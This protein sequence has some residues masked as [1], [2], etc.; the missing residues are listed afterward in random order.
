[1]LQY[2]V[3]NKELFS[4]YRRLTTILK[5]SGTGTSSSLP[6]ISHSGEFRR[7][8]FGVFA[9]TEKR[10]HNRLSDSVVGSADSDPLVSLIYTACWA[11]LASFT[12]SGALSWR[13]WPASKFRKQRN[14]LVYFSSEHCLPCRATLAS[15]TSQDQARPLPIPWPAPSKNFP[16]SF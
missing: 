1:M 10:F 7:S 8:L 4:G 14:H 2:P 16:A 12:A 6:S 11:I 3:R 15:C 13:A 9:C 5:R